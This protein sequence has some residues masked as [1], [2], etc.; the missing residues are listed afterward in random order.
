[1]SSSSPSG[2]ASKWI[3]AVLSLLACGVAVSAEV[4]AEVRDTRG[5]PVAGAVVWVTPIGSKIPQKLMPAIVAHQNK[6]FVPY[7]TAVQV[8]TTI[9]LPNL[10]DVKHHAYSF[11]PAKKFELPLYAGTPE[12]PLLFDKPGIVTIGCNIHDWMTAYV[13]VVETPFFAISGADGRV[14]LRNLPA[15]AYRAEVWQ[16]RLK[17]QPADYAQPFTIQNEAVKLAFKLDLKLEFRA[18]RNPAT[19]D[20]RYP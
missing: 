18:R 19:L 1:M 4:M 7:V 15:G 9:N 8:G 14:Q 3:A 11:S 10:D 5:A 6:Q 20:G 16:P 17:G 2:S 13:C 12:A